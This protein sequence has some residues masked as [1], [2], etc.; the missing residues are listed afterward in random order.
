MM[1]IN[2]DVIKN[3][4]YLIPGY[5]SSQVKDCTKRLLDTRGSGDPEGIIGFINGYLLYMPKDGL[6]KDILTIAEDRGLIHNSFF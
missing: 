6:R 2:D 4:K 5:L 1:E 3:K